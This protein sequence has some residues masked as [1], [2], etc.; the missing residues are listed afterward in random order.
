MKRHL[1]TLLPLLA[2]VLSLSLAGCLSK[3][4]IE[5]SEAPQQYRVPRTLPDSLTQKTIQFL[6]FGDTQTGWRAEHKF[7]R[8]ENWFTWK[9]L[10]FP[11]YQ[12][13]LL[14]NGVVGAANWGRGTPDYGRWSRDFMGDALHKESR[15]VDSDFTLMLGDIADDGRRAELW[16][17][18]FDDYGRLVREYPFLPVAGNHEYTNDATGLDNYDAVFDYPR[19]YV[20]DMPE[21]A[22]FVLNSN[23]LIDQ[24]GLVDDDRQDALWEKWFVSSDTSS[25]PSWLEA[26]LERRKD[27]PFKLIAMHHPVL[28]YA[29]HFKDWVNGTHGR[30]LEEKRDQLLDL[31]QKYHVQVILSGHEHLYEH[32]ILRWGSEPNRQELHQVISS[33]GGTPPRGIATQGEI[34]ER[35]AYYRARGLDVEHLRQESAF[36]FTRVEVAP[37]ALTLETI[38]VGEYGSHDTELLER[39]VIPRPATRQAPAPPEQLEPTP[40][41]A[42]APVVE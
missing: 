28:T 11:F 10:M 21:A 39:I 8:S 38:E 12:A 16:E 5:S 32:D 31:L 34:E 4:L 19:F 33:G 17:W 35:Q 36:H 3:G 42:P 15:A 22:L 2:L 30:N 9:H 26:Q 1:E 13:Y 6:V 25:S 7:Y 27:R 40:Q 14:G 20:Q 37:E 41:E 18:F 23:Y 29:W 24:H